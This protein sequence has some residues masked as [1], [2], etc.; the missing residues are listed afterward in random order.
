MVDDPKTDTTRYYYPPGKTE[1]ELRPEVAEVAAA[2]ADEYTAEAKPL[3]GKLPEDFPGLSPLEAADV[4][5]YAGVR[6]H[7]DSLEEIE[8]IGP[9]TAEKI[10]EAM[11]ESSADEEEAE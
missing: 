2:K 8:G 1:P 4:T 10:Q 7:L 5:T 11:G 3:R 9:A 6:K